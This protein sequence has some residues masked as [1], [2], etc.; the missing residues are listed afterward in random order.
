M[1][2]WGRGTKQQQSTLTKSKQKKRTSNWGWA[3]HREVEGPCSPSASEFATLSRVSP[4]D[5]IWL[6]PLYHLPPERK[7]HALVIL[8]RLQHLANRRICPT[9][10]LIRNKQ[11]H[12]PRKL[13]CLAPLADSLCIQRVKATERIQVRMPRDLVS[14][15]SK[16]KPTRISPGHYKFTV[17]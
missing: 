10:L 12:K 9:L 6:Y 11:G 16:D 1:T 7:I 4:R 3:A 17:M 15:T 2:S 14:I 13:A 8:N 5:I